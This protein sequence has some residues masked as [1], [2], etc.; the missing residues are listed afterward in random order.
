MQDY[1]QTDQQIHW[2]CQI[3]AKANRSYVPKKEDDSHTN[4]FFDVL[5][6]RIIGRWIKTS[7]GKI[8][9]SLNLENLRLEWLGDHLQVLQSVASV[10]KSDLEIIRELTQEVQKRGLQPA[11]FSEK[12]HFEITEYPFSQTPVQFIPQEHIQV[13]KHWRQLANEACLW[14][15][16][17]LQADGEIRIWPHHFD[18]GIYVPANDRVSI[19]FGWAMEDSLAGAPYF[20]VAGYAPQGSLDYQELPELQTGKWETG[21][22]FKGAI[23]S[24]NE[25]TN[26]NRDILEKALFEF[27]QKTIGFFLK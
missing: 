11:D 7:S 14:V 20:Y 9:L 6:N 8:I 23:L 19:G 18:T 12:L 10:G 27:L 16:G 3:I 25:M 24:L 2:L 5:G 17:Y 4:L 15:L 22:H 21:G 26:L 1:T 13:W